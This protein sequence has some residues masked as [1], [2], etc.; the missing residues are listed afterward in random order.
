MRS[1]ARCCVAAALAL[2]TIP[3]LADVSF[4]RMIDGIVHGNHQRSGGSLDIADTTSTIVP[5]MDLFHG[6]CVQLLPTSPDSIRATSK[7]MNWT[8][9]TPDE[10]A[11]FAIAGAD[12]QGWRTTH[13]GQLFFIGISQ[14]VV[15]G[16]KVLS[17]GITARGPSPEELAQ[18]LFTT[19]RARLISDDQEGP[20]RMQQFVANTTAGEMI[21][22]IT[23]HRSVKTVTVAAQMF[24]H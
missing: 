8:P 18:E 7:I 2:V 20:Q 10:A 3:A 5:L 16:K 21:F 24:T 6:T 11:M 12:F 23:S 17:C 13:R 22:A 1:L 9:L 4:D 15:D 19:Y 14:A